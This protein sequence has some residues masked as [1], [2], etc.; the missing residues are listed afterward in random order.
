[1]FSTDSEEIFVEIRGRSF[2]KLLQAHTYN[3]LHT[4]AACQESLTYECVDS[5]HWCD[6]KSIWSRANVVVAMQEIQR[7]QCQRW[8]VFYLSTSDLLIVGPRKRHTK[9]LRQTDGERF[10]EYRV[11][12]EIAKDF[13]RSDHRVRHTSDIKWSRWCEWCD[14]VSSRLWD[15]CVFESEVC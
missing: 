5:S 10:F 15:V 4:W 11:H 9:Q 1:M 13:P 12:V 6:H 7:W 2:T 8:C 14:H 3:I